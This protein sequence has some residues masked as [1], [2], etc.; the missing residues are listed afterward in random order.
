MR[1][2]LVIFEEIPEDTKLYYKEVTDDEFVILS[3]ASG[4]I[5]N[6]DWDDQ[7]TI[8][9]LSMMLNTPEWEASQIEIRRGTP[10]TPG[11]IDAIIFTGFFM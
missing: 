11:P 2:V 9:A 5:I 10:L 1:K 3:K 6:T 4:N 8:D 7:E